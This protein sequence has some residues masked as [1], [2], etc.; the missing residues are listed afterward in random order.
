M[1]SGQG[2]ELLPKGAKRS[3]KVVAFE[4]DDSLY[5]KLVHKFAESQSVE[6]HHENFLTAT[7]PTTPYKVFS[8]IPFNITADVI[9]GLTESNGAVQDIYLI[10]QMEAA[11]KFVGRPATFETQASLLI[12]PWFEGSLI[13]QFKRTDF[14]PVPK[15]NIGLLR[16]KRREKPKVADARLYRD[17]ISFAFNQWKPTLLE[18]LKSIF[19]KAQF[20]KLSRNLSFNPLSKPTQLDFDQWMGLYNY[21]L[22]GVTDDKKN[23]VIGAA[24][25]LA[26]Q[27]KNLQKIHRSRVAK[28]W[29]KTK[30]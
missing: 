15:V 30:I 6:I 2:K 4:I 16:L 12:K 11:A 29:R 23:I 28:N 25:K 21:F 20:V 1:R 17:F 26:N 27:Q 13:H 9:R 8:N 3:R 19:T 18:A 24:D 14:S 22:V 10:V 7:L 5:S